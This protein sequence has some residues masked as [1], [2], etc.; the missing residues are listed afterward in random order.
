[1]DSLSGLAEQVEGIE[2]GQNLLNTGK[3][4][5]H[6]SDAASKIG[7]MTQE[8]L[9]ATGTGVN[10][11]IY[12]M[13]GTPANKTGLDALNAILPN[14]AQSSDRWNAEKLGQVYPQDAMQQLLALKNQGN[15]F[16]SAAAQIG[17][18]ISRGTARAGHANRCWMAYDAAKRAHGLPLLAA[19]ALKIAGRM[20]PGTAAKNSALAEALTAQG[21]AR[22]SIGAAIGDLL[23]R[24]AA[25]RVAGANIAPI[26][27]GAA[28]GNFDR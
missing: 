17:A 23:A 18:Q 2:Y 12:R 3:T 9:E 15:Q 13:A 27:A 20:I 7:G 22:D 10:S 14:E 25:G 24:R 16:R 28:L 19:N 11:E 8:E 1:M 21:P 6:P 4:A 26:F 5:V